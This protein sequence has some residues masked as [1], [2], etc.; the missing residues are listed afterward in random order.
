MEE[1]Y[2]YN[3]YKKFFTNELIMVTLTFNAIFKWHDLI[4]SIIR[5]L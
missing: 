2:L 3:T 1:I 5:F 4:F